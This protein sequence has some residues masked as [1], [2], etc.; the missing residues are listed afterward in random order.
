MQW[1]SPWTLVVG[2]A[3]A[4]VVAGLVTV[5]YLTKDVRIMVDGHAVAVRSFAG[6]VHELL[7][8]AHVEVG[9]GDYLFPGG[10]EDLADGEQIVVKHAR[11]I[12]LTVDG[13]TTRRLVTAGNVGDALTELHITQAG[14]RISAPPSGAVPL[15]GM[16]LTMFTRRRVYVQASGAGAWTRTTGASVREVLR[17]QRIRL[18]AGDRVEPPLDSFPRDGTVIRVI[19]AGTVLPSH[20]LPVQP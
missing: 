4:L 14:G 6:S 5:S 18:R 20:T 17:Q 13:H 3:V 10:Q 15:Q 7:D 8:E 2:V 16:A 11:P 9:F 12:T 19:P 1:R